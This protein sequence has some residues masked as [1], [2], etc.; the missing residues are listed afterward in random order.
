MGLTVTAD[1][2]RRTFAYD[3][4]RLFW[5][6][7]PSGRRLPI[8]APVGNIT[9]GGYRS[10]GWKYQKWA[11]HRLVFLIAHGYLPP[12][13]D[14]INGDRDDNRAENLRAASR[15]DNLKNSRTRADNTSGVKGVHWDAQR[16][17]WKAQIKVGDKKLFLGFAD[18]PQDLAP[19]V[20]AAREQ[21]HGAFANHGR[22]QSD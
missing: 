19:A 16:G 22:L 21:H 10:V 9:T 20:R 12:D 6:N 11:V 2:A 15:S 4:G 7:N 13:V 8:N 5:R 1:E 14:H 18:N 3:G 17:K